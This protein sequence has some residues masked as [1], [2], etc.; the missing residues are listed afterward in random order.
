MTDEIKAKID[1]INRAKTDDVE[2]HLEERAVWL[3]LPDNWSKCSNCGNK[4]RTVHEKNNC[5]I[6][7]KPM[8]AEREGDTNL[9]DRNIG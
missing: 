7:G 4:L 5:N 9:W 2:I 1:E 8:R 3:R 6:C